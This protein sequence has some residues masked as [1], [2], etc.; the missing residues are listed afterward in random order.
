VVR[1]LLELIR[2]R[3]EHPAFNGR[4]ELE[5]TGDERLRLRWSAGS[6]YALLDAD[7]ASGQ[8]RL[9][10]SQPGAAARGGSVEEYV[11]VQ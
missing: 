1:S 7:L 4:F 2:L 11:F 6:D 10:A 9:S 8:W 5:E 3:N